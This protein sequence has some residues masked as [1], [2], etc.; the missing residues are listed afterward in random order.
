MAAAYARNV[1]RH[2]RVVAEN[3]AWTD[4][5]KLRKG[6]IDCGYAEHPV[7]LDFDHRDP[8]MKTA[9]VSSL[10]S[11]TLANIQAELEKCEV[12]C[13]CCHRIKTYRLNQS[14]N[15]RRPA[16]GITG[17]GPYPETTDHLLGREQRYGSSPSP[18]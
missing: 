11:S 9:D 13:A 7:A 16:P 2:A 5:Y 8:E 15:R 6:C 3:Q 1:E 4:A 12:R 10:M 14:Q 18:P 17:D